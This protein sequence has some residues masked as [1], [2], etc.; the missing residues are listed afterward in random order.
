MTGVYLF[1]HRG[2]A[3]EKTISVYEDGF[4]FGKKS[5]GWEE[6]SGFWLLQG[7]G[8]IELHIGRKKA[9]DLTIQTGHVEIEKIRAVFGAILT[10]QLD[11]RENILDTIIR[12]CKL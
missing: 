5:I 6:C 3:A 7:R 2:P 9:S 10:E 8:Y 4:L 1:V 12:I 11:K